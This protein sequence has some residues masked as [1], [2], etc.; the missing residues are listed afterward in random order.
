MELRHALVVETDHFGVENGRAFDMRCFLRDA[1]V[2]IRPIAGIHCVEPHPPISDMDLQPVAVML[3]FMRPAGARRGL[4]GDG[5]PARTDESGRRVLGPA[6]RDT[7][8]PQHERHLSKNRSEIRIFLCGAENVPKGAVG[9]LFSDFWELDAPSRRHGASMSQRLGR[10]AIAWMILPEGDDLRWIFY[11][12]I[13]GIWNFG[14]ITVRN[15]IY[16][17]LFLIS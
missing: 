6:A 12:L 5:R 1:R 10:L 17:N 16:G 7:H 9:S 4:L 2:A 3:Q 11:F 13:F 15:L 8:T 14:F